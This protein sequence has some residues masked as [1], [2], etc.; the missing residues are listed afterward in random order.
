MIYENET[1]NQKNP[2]DP[3]YTAGITPKRVTSGGAQPRSLAPGKQFRENVAAI[4][5]RWQ[6]CVQFD[7]PRNRTRTYR[8]SVT[9]TL[10]G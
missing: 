7:Q 9:T 6:R 1:Q 8:G 5:S 10:T 2:I 4:A 3:H